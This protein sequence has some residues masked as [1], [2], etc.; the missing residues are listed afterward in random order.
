MFKA[1]RFS[2]IP[3]KNCRNRLESALSNRRPIGRG[4]RHRAA[5]IAIQSALADLNRGYLLSAE[6]DGYFG[7]RTYAGVE[8]FQRDYGLVADGQVGKQ[9]LTQLDTLFSGDVLRQAMGVSIHIGV[10]I[11]DADHY[12]DSFPLAS[13]ENDARKM[14]GIAEA[15]G[16]DALTFVNED[17][18]VLNFTGFM[19]NA[20]DNLY[21]GDSLFV[22]FSGH[23]S[24]IPNTSVDA[25]DDNR[26]ETLCFY[27][28]MLVD[29]EL[30]AL[31]AQFREG[32]RVH[33][34][35]DSCHS[36]TVAKR[37]EVLESERQ[38]YMTKSLTSIKS[39]NNIGEGVSDNDE[40]LLDMMPISG[41]NL[42]K[43]LGGDQPE[44]MK[45]ARPKEDSSENIASLF[46]D[47]YNEE[48]AGKS[49]NIEFF[50]GIYERN[51]ALYDTV[52]NLVGPKEAKQLLCSVVSLSACQDSQTTP[53]GAVL[54]L[55]TANINNVWSSGGFEG[56]YR[57]FHKSIVNSTDRLDVVPAINTYGSNRAL[58]RL[59][60]RPFYI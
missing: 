14:H 57:E 22:S 50:A 47:L 55:F 28:R 12:G 18:T 7:S 31:L 16:Y 17:A 52:K 20:I 5:V 27:D 45:A 3:T 35:F 58:V 15:L 46:A 51:K 44:L 2:T 49:K 33:L 21:D 34:A 32:V 43:T 37:L 29:D 40:V 4:E 11:V 6:V 26:D 13:C 56:S 36:G 48:N 1:S 38:D 54:S 23:G 41:K 39:L 59:Y 8:A 42:S 60:E 53:A 9:T 30:Y 19:R 10:D 25:E 24:Q